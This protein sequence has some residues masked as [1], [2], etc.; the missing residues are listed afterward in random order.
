MSSNCGKC[1]VKLGI[2]EFNRMDNKVVCDNCSEGRIPSNSPIP[3]DSTLKAVVGFDQLKSAEG[4]P[5]KMFKIAFWFCLIMTVLFTID[6]LHDGRLSIGIIYIPIL[7]GIT[8]TMFRRD[9]WRQSYTIREH[10]LIITSVS[11]QSESTVDL[12]KVER[13]TE[14]VGQHNCN[15]TLF[16]K[17]G[18]IAIIFANEI[19]NYS[20]IYT[21]IKQNLDTINVGSY[22]TKEV[23]SLGET[24]T[25]FVTSEKVALKN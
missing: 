8:Y 3:E 12:R 16:I 4:R 20:E 18:A 2:Y 15:L 21:C 19:K 6:F 23:V 1:G 7:A 14:F 13:Y 22:F 25:T 9:K 24:T 5:T 10:L 17:E 11:D